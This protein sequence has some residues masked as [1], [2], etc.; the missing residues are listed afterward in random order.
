MA[1]QVLMLANNLRQKVAV[2]VAR[3]S[4]MSLMALAA[5]SFRTQVMGQLE[6]T[7]DAQERNRTQWTSVLF[8]QHVKIYPTIRL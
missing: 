1:N 6:G 2:P 3:S 4:Q 5:Q 8:F 7:V